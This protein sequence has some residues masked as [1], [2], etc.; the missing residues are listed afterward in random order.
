MK[1]IELKENDVSGMLVDA[2]FAVHKA[3]GP[4]LLESAYEVCLEYELISRGFKVER[5]KQ[6]PIIYKGVELQNGFRLD[7]CVEDKVIVELKS[8]DEISN[9][10]LAQMMTYLKLS[11]LKLGLIVNFNSP[12]ISTGI[13]RVVNGL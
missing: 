9:L 13:K 10:H 2:C 11:R 12:L 5:Q 4:G 6:L 1:N 7:L 8:V 3:L